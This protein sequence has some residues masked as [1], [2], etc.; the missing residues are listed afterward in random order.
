MKLQD[1]IIN[2]FN[3]WEEDYFFAH[4]SNE[5]FTSDD[6]DG[7]G[8][9]IYFSQDFKLGKSY[10]VYERQVYSIAGVLQDVGGFFNS[11]FFLGLF[12]YK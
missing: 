3:D 6:L 10:D 12:L 11:L 8:Y 9:G 1:N 4:D 2:L 5:Y 7:L